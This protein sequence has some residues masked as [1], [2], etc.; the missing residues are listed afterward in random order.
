MSIE[1]T[2]NGPARLQAVFV[3]ERAGVGEPRAKR[4]DPS[5]FV[6]MT[7]AWAWKAR[8][9]APQQSFESYAELALAIPAY[10]LR[11]GL[12]ASPAMIAAEILRS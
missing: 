10:N 1:H 4:L 5:P 9:L 11:A 3:L 7:H 6:F 8:A 2:S 12:D